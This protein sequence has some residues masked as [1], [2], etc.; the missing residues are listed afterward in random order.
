MSDQGAVGAL[1]EGGLSAAGS[2]SGASGRI[3]FVNRFFFPDQSATSRM[4]S[5]LAWH[6]AHH[7]LS[8]CVVTS[9][10][11]Y[12][13]RLADLPAY[14]VE[15][16]VEIH[17]VATATRGRGSLAGRALDYGSFYSAAAMELARILK[18]GDIV[19]AKTDP[20]LVSI[21]VAA[22]A[23]LKGAVLIN[24]LQDLF[25]EVAA[26]LTP[27]LLPGWLRTLLLVARD[28]SLRRARMNVVLGQTMRDRVLARGVDPARVATIPN[29][30][31][32][33]EIVPLPAQDST[34][35]RKLGLEGK[36]VVGYSGN[37]GRAHEF[38]TLVAAASAL[39]ADAD[40]AF[41]MTGAGARS[42][43]LQ[44]AVRGENLSSFCFQDYQPPDLL[45]DSM[46]AAD[47]HL[48]SLLPELE[49]LIV[50]SK[51]YG[52]LA[53]GRPAVFIGDT[54]GEV[55]AVLRAHQC[56]LSVAVGDAAGLAAQLRALRADPQ[57]LQSMGQRARAASL[58]QFNCERA[59]QAWLEMIRRVAPS[60]VRA[61]RVVK[62]AQQ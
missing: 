42:G 18:R 1:R 9:R 57:R 56:G 30:A 10:Q 59:A 51:L 61:D 34:I 23:R 39:R 46:A 60:V 16:G 11:L 33:Q 45:S 31:D 55:A 7:G 47:V 4:L 22:V 48:V 40:I 17:R 21:P 28:R 5:D 53:A 26:V 25:P 44:E 12:S 35:R 13:N 6:L 50:P 43:P 24:W 29:W 37:F 41:L 36:F 20:P 15:R 2:D 54:G 32:P 14:A 8:V 19:V 49:G 62:E 58:G 3:V 27:R 52:I 38:G